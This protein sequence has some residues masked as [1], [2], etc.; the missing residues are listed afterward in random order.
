MTRG[1]ELNIP[2]HTGGKLSIKRCYKQKMVLKLLK[3]AED[4][5]NYTYKR[6]DAYLIKQPRKSQ[7]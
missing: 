1:V 2:F 3:H 5:K 6:S 4:K 7:L